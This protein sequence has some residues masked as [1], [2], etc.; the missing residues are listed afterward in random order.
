MNTSNDSSGVQ[1]SQLSTSSTNPQVVRQS[2]LFH[3]LDDHSLTFRELEDIF[4]LAWHNKLENCTQKIDGS[5]LWFTYKTSTRE[6]RVARSN[7]EILLGG[8]NRKELFQKYSSDFCVKMGIQRMFDEAIVALDEL[9]CGGYKIELNDVFNDGNI[10]F[11]IEVVYPNKDHTILISSYHIVFHYY[12]IIDNKLTE[13][14]IDDHHKIFQLFSDNHPH[15]NNNLNSSLTVHHP[16]KALIDN[17]ILYR[18]YEI[19]NRFSN[20]LSNLL[21]NTGL[22]KDN[23]IQDYLSYRMFEHIKQNEQFILSSIEP[24]NAIVN[25][26]LH[27]KGCHNVTQL[28]QLCKSSPTS[29][30]LS[31]YIDNKLFY[32]HMIQ[33]LEDIFNN[34]AHQLLQNIEPVV[35]GSVVMT[36]INVLNIINANWWKTLKTI[37]DELQIYTEKLKSTDNI[38]PL[39]GVVFFYKNKYYKMTG[40]FAAA[41]QILNLERRYFKNV[42]KNS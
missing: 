40:Y 5:F 35:K 33:P 11:P 1:Q 18:K 12:P 20:D 16:I 39:E 4:F 22:T 14:K 3:V 8:L 27:I 38:I 41:N 26:V 10:F 17:K 32:H 21:F 6:I 19:L 34:Y 36:Q 28:K 31:K 42:T 7:K 30:D 15:W 29:V 25:R 23:T 24:I 2:K 37:P 13:T 9:L